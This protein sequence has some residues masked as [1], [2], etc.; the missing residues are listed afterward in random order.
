MDTEELRKHYLVS[1]LMQPGKLNLV[2][3]HHD[4]VIIGGAVPT[5]KALALPNEAEL[6]AN[7]FWSA[8]SWA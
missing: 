5:T 7:Y 8:A 3:S 2:Y 1:N 6:R 4:R